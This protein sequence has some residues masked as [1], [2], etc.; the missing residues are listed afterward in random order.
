MALVKKLSVIW[1]EVFNNEVI[2]SNLE[3]IVI[4]KNLYKCNCIKN[5]LIGLVFILLNFSINTKDFFKF[6]LNTGYKNSL[7][8]SRFFSKNVLNCFQ[9]IKIYSISFEVYAFFVLSL[10]SVNIIF[11]KKSFEI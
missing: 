1:I 7:E 8:L 3:K 5:S 9:T 2:L 11:F 6:I 10:I 4:L